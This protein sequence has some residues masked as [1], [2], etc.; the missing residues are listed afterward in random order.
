MTIDY[1]DS[2]IDLMLICFTELILKLQDEPIEDHVTVLP[3]NWLRSKCYCEECLNAKLAK[4][5]VIQKNI[6]KV[7]KEKNRIIP[8]MS[9]KEF[10][11]NKD[12]GVFE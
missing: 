2:F 1:N 7:Q 6:D 11:N 4:S 3:L 10:E 12:K 5:D 9:F 8:T